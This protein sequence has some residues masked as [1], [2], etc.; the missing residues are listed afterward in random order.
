MFKKLVAPFELYNEGL[1]SSVISSDDHNDLGSESC[2]SQCCRVEKKREQEGERETH[3]LP[4]PPAMVQLLPAPQGERSVKH[5]VIHGVSHDAVRL[6]VETLKEVQAVGG[7][8]ECEP[9]TVHSIRTV[10]TG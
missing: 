10:F 3:R 5:W 2:R 6:W 1:V 7:T 8:D 9:D 4:P